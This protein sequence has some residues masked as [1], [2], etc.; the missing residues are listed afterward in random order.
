MPGSRGGGD[1]PDEM[2]R[3]IG[4]WAR[5]EAAL[6]NAAG[7][8]AEKIYLLHALAAAWEGTTPRQNLIACKQ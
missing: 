8:V 7:F 2:S 3:A 5:M 4:Q 1:L 6:V